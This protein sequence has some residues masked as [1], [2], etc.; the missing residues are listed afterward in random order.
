MGLPKGRESY[1]NGVSIVVR[2]RES[3]SHGE[4]KQVFSILSKGGTR[5]AKCRND[6]RNHP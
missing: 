1:G 2:E 3:R 4:G 6:S 5:D